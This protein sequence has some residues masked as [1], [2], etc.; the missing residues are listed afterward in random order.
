MEL[1]DE[2]RDWIK[3]TEVLLELA[4]EDGIV[5]IPPVRGE[6]PAASRLQDLLA[7]AY[8]DEWTASTVPGLLEQV[9]YKGKTLEQWLRD[10]FFEQHCQLFHQRP[11]IWHVWDGQRR[12]GFAVLV[13]YHD[14]DRKLLERL[15]YT[16]LGNWI[17]Q[18]QRLAKAGE[19]GAENKL[20][21]ALELQKKLELI[22]EGEPP[23]DIFVR[24]KPIEEQS[25]GWEPDL[26]DGV[27]INIRPFVQA[28]ILRKNPKIR[29]SRDR[30]KEPPRDGKQYP[31]YW[32]DGKFTGERVNDVHLT[33]ADKRA[34]RQRAAEQIGD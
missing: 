25:I 29:W 17:D 8:R 31:W 3:R 34:A 30:G 26:N 21:A 28:G 16:Y 1:S 19:R 20:A 24:W 33:N 14:L 23:Y 12:D 5:C 13:N 27:R 6:Q 18:Q 4:D 15:T 32:N 2:A 11:F 10:G 9:G 7:R 22:L